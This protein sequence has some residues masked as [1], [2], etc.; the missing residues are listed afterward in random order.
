MKGLEHLKIL[1]RA[2]KEKR[3]IS[4]SYYN[5]STEK[6]KQYSL[7]PYLVREYQDRWYIVGI[8][9]TSSDFRTF[10][11]DRIETIEMSDKTFRIT[12]DLN[13]AELFDDIVGVNY[14]NGKTEK[15]VLSFTHLKGKYIKSL[16]MHKSQKIILDTENELRVEPHVIPN[17]ELIHKILMHGNEVKVLEPKWLVNDIKKELQE[18]L[19]NYRQ[20]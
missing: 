18:T 6:T 5:F 16:P 10:G 8:E 7:K 17:Y 20:D 13:A 2:V 3:I 9:K 14:S 12:K 15:V 11:I 1:L 4:F 19:E